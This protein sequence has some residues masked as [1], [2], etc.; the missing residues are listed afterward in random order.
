M[1]FHNLT[2]FESLAYGA[3]DTHDEEHHV[4]VTRVVYRLVSDGGSATHRCVAVT[5]EDVC[6]L[7]TEDVF[8]GEVNASSVVAE[9]DIAPFK[10]RCDVVVHATAHAPN[11]VAS[12]RWSVR[13]RVT[14]PDPPHASSERDAPRGV[15]IDKTLSVCGPR[16]FERSLDG[17]WTLTEPIAVKTVPMRWERAFGGRSVVPDREHA[18]RMLLNEVCFTNPLG[19]GWV[20]RRHFEA[21]EKAA[22]EALSSL[23]APQIE[24][25]DHGVTSLVVAEHPPHAVEAPAMAELAASYG[26][27]PAGLG[28]VGRAWTPRL[29]R[30]GTYDDAWV[31]ARHPFLPDD[32]KFAYWNGAPDDQQIAHPGLGLSIEL[33]NLAAPTHSRDGCVRFTL[34][35]HRAFVM[36]WMRGLPVPVP[37]VI[38]TVRVD[39][40]AMTVTCL[41]RVLIARSLGVERLDARFETDPEAHLLKLETAHG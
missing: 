36:A 40:E 23:P 6:A 29:Q 16:R 34:P 28:F 17:A 18:D 31:R 3:L 38:D 39:A 1:E 37:A 25:P 2:P 32:F 20:E 33:W 30:A 11:D 13:M 26:A 14:A 5:D 12:T 4:V 19:A 15:L 10:P 24:H 35:P 41:W 21:H 22:G 9:S 27:T 8:E 7:V